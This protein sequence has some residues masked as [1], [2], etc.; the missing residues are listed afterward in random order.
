MDDELAG[1]CEGGQ[2]RRRWFFFPVAV[3]QYAVGV[4]LN[5]QSILF[6]FQQL[7]LVRELLRAEGCI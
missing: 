5:Q 7:G 2:D 3:G 4:T 1:N 6:D